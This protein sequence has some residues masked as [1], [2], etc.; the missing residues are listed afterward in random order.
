MKIL[1]RAVFAL[2]AAVI[3]LPVFA[4]SPSLAADGVSPTTGVAGPAGPDALRQGPVDAPQLQN[5]GIWKASP[6]GICMTSA[7]R[8]GEYVHQGCVYD[9]EGGGPQYRWPVDTLV[10]G[11]TYPEDKAYRRNAAD[12]LEVRVKP[13]ADA[14]AIRA[15]MN[16]MT[17]P[18]LLGLTVALGSSAEKREAPFG[19]NTVMP[20]KTFVTVHGTSG[21]ITDAATGKDSSTRAGVTVDVK[22]RQVEIRV[23]HTAYD[24]TGKTDAMRLAAGLWDRENN[25]YLV[26]A[27]T[28][29]ETHPG[30]ATVGDPSP[31]VFFDSAFRFKEPFEAPYREALQRKA[32]IAGDLTP[33][34]AD[35]DY[36]KL[37]KGTN[38]ESDVPTTGYMT[39]VFATR[40]EKEQGRRLPSD[41]GGPPAG[42][43]TQQGGMQSGT[44]EG[45]KGFSLQFGWVCRDS[46]VPD[47]PGRMQRYMVYVPEAAAPANGYSSM[48]WTPGYALRPED[49]VAGKQDL[50]QSFAHLPGNPTMVIDVDARGNDQWFYGDSGSTVFEALADAR[51]HYPLDTERTTMGGFSSGAYGANKLSLQFPDVFNKAF[52][53]DGLEKAASFPGLNA[54]A[55]GLPVDTLTKHE[56]GSQ[57]S[58]LLPSRRN[59][60]VIEWAGIN[61]DFIPYNITRAR[62]DLYAKGTYDYSFVSWAGLGAEHLVMCKNGMWK[63][64]SDFLG[65]EPRAVNPHHV[66]YVRNPMMDDPEAGLVGDRAYW[67]SNIQTRV[68]ARGRIDVVSSGL[69]LKDAPVTPVK[70]ELGTQSGTVSPVNP[71]TQETRKLAEPVATKKENAL[72]VTASNIKSITI[73]PKRAGVDCNA[74]ISVD[75]DGPLAVT[76]TGCGEKNFA[77]THEPA[78]K[79]DDGTIPDVLGGLRDNASL[80]EVPLPAELGNLPALPLLPSLPPLRFP[81]NQEDP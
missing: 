21:T 14:T 13:L 51:R 41:P 67:V 53:C 50:Y 20:A 30:G 23:P 58:P 61:D 10:R 15:T 71:Y 52:I 2:A 6:I 60:P 74:A 57:I 29:T 68:K 55:D 31:S 39:R 62:G 59:Q 11:Y 17:D 77:A 63:V 64:A 76:L 4:A 34:V 44:G 66:T 46:C 3:G 9:D 12:I 47:L 72:Q 5:T 22:R 28:A 42:S 78:S 26:P 40:S 33:F 1:R 19:A 24:P 79:P 38:D 81:P 65:N 48:V 43:G 27:V 36:M 56:A 73:D 25:R 7:Y 69:G 35:I 70:T 75:T 80:K 54:V 37:A 8:S 32:I 16:T 45:S 49:D 18:E